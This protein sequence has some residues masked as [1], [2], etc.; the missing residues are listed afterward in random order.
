[1]PRKPL[2]G[3]RRRLS[4]PQG[5]LRLKRFFPAVPGMACAWARVMWLASWGHSSTGVAHE[6]TLGGEVMI[7]VRG[8]SRS[9]ARKLERWDL[10]PFDRQPF[11]HT[12]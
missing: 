1:M 4:C 9:V 12:L 2:R 6:H 7:V 8:N 3:M 11:S 10:P 5:L